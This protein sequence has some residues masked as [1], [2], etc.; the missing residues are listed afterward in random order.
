ML[1]IAASYASVAIRRTF[2]SVDQQSPALRFA[3]RFFRRPGPGR[4]HEHQAGRRGDTRQQA[5]TGK[6]TTPCELAVVGASLQRS[7]P[8]PA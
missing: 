6:K 1:L 7:T 5:E 4:A 3:G 2:V 8:L